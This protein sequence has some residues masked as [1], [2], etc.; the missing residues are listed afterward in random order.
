MHRVFEDRLVVADHR[1]TFRKAFQNRV[2]ATFED[3]LM[4]ISAL[5][6]VRMFTRLT[7]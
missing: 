1:A 2:A 6:Q 4:V 3:E 5:S 7:T